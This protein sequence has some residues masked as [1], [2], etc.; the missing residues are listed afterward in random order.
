MPR[1]SI[2]P[3]DINFF[4]R[5]LDIYPKCLYH[6]IDEFS[7]V[8]LC[9]VHMLC[10]IL[11]SIGVKVFNLCNLSIKEPLSFKTEFKKILNVIF[12]NK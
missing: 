6:S 1:E 10:I 3:Y 2:I 5:Y 4:N 11:L 12:S 8:K 7:L 9:F